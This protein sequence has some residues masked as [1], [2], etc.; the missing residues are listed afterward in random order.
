MKKIL[1]IFVL[2]L[3][4]IQGFAGSCPD[5]SEPVK[6]I[7]EDGTYFLYHCNI[8]VNPP[9]EEMPLPPEEMPLPPEETKPNPVGYKP[10]WKIQEGSNFWSVDLDSPYWKTE[11]GSKEFKAS[12]KRGS[13]IK[14]EASAYAKE[15]PGVDE[16]IESYYATNGCGEG[17]Q[18]ANSSC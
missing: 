4:S 17:K 8:V 2:S 15:N 6:S 1:F 10:G 3:Y 12:K 18:P 16:P 9:P 7:S 13:W 14:Q 5:G 11:E